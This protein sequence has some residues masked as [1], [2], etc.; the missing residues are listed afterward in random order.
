MNQTKQIQISI[1]TYKTNQQP[2]PMTG[3]DRIQLTTASLTKDSTP[4]TPNR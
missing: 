2:Q 3:Y 4:L 1:N